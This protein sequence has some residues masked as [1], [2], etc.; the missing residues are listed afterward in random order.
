[1]P[2][3]ICFCIFDEYKYID[4]INIIILTIMALFRIVLNR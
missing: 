2:S 4:M 3:T 1:M